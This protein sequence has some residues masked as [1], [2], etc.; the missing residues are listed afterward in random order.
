VH[1]VAGVSGVQVAGHHL[2]CQVRGPIDEL[3]TVL[4]AGH[5][6]TLLS[7]EPSLEELFLSIYGEQ[8]R[9]N[10]GARGG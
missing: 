7:R 10:D 4:A 3:L 6:E 9:M 2:S 8:E 1:K 5:P